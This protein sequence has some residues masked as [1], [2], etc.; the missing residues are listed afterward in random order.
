MATSKTRP[1]LIGG[2]DVGQHTSIALLDLAG[3]VVHLVTLLHPQNSDLLDRITELGNV[4]IIST[5]RAKPPSQVRK[6]AASIDARM[7]LPAKNMTKKKKRILIEDFME[8]REREKRMN[9]HEKSALA[10]AI[11]AYKKFR[12]G[13]KKLEDRVRKESEANLEKSRN[14]LFLRMIRDI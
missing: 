6:I 14:E 5:D 7:I 8:N 11:F 3:N 9:G 10:S 12:P 4:M 2:L 13:F 1:F